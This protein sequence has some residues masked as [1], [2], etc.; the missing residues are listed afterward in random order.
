M[1]V[2]S[3]TWFSSGRAPRKIKFKYRVPGSERHKGSPGSAPE[4]GQ[5]LH[6]SQ[7]WSHCTPQTI[8]G[9]DHSRAHSRAHF[10]T[11]EKDRH[12]THWS[13]SLSRRFAV[14]PSSLGRLLVVS[15]ST[16][17]GHQNPILMPEISI[18]YYI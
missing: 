11:N 8:R 5:I 12:R 13:P 1:G 17:S 14:S 18:Y 4:T 9:P 6:W 16:S 3:C 7:G 10:R 15:W 2:R